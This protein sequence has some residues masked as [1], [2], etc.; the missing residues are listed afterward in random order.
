MNFFRNADIFPELK[1]KNISNGRSIYIA[2]SEP[3]QILQFFFSQ[4][5]ETN[6]LHM[7][8]MCDSRLNN[9]NFL[10]EYAQKFKIN[11]IFTLASY[12]F[13]VNDFNNLEIIHIRA[14]GDNNDL[15]ILKQ[16]DK[17]NCKYIN[18][19]ASSEYLIQ[20]ISV[21]EKSNLMS[22]GWHT[23]FAYEWKLNENKELMIFYKNQWV[24]T[25]DMFN[26]RNSQLFFIGRNKPILQGS[27]KDRER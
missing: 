17:N 23:K 15:G 19:F 12:F 2:Y 18:V 10:A 7:F 9:P 16:I 26:Q 24:N 21:I 22:F 20:M 11:Y 1:F 6:C 3:A 27:I 13:N 8:D 14:I 4:Y 5:I 25:G